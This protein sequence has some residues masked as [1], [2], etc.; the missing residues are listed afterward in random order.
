MIGSKSHDL[1]PQYDVQPYLP[2]L[3][4]VLATRYLN[5]LIYLLK[6]HVIWPERDIIQ[7]GTFECGN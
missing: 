2:Y 5:S 6:N 7:L 3:T 4:A 1:V